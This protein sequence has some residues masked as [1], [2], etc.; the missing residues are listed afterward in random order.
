MISSRSRHQP[1][2]DGVLQPVVVVREGAAGFVRWVNEHTLD[3]PVVKNAR[4]HHPLLGVVAALR[5][6]QQDARLQPGALIFADLG[7]F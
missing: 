2:S 5:V 1:Q 6:F 3:E 4:V 7:E